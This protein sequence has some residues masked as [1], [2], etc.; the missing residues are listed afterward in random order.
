MRRRAGAGAVVLTTV[1]LLVGCG[2]PPWERAAPSGTASA[3]SDATSTGDATPEPSSPSAGAVATGDL[4]GGNTSRS[5]T[6]GAATLAVD[7]WTD[8]AAAQWTAGATKPVSLSV[9]ASEP[10]GSEIYLQRLR[11]VPTALDASGAALESPAAFEDA[12]SITPGYLM[13]DPYSYSTSFSIGAVDPA[14]RSIRLDLTYEVLQRAQPG[15]G[16]FAK[17]TA[18]DTLTLGVVGG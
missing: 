6:A 17:Q 8:L 9:T 13:S 12:S 1:V 7:Y 2:T 14:T 16:D 15:S 4:A 3:T 10:G 18:H 11:A 5:L